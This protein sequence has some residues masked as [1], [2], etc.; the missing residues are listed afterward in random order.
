MNGLLR[1]EEQRCQSKDRENVVA[2][3]VCA[4]S[5]SLLWSGIHDAFSPQANPAQSAPL[6]R[7]DQVLQ[8]LQPRGSLLAT[9]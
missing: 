2:V 1:L 7:Q 3:W 6:T 8:T 9:E 4:A 5:V